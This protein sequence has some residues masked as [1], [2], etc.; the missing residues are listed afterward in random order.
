MPSPKIGLQTHVWKMQLFVTETQLKEPALVVVRHWMSY[1]L[2][3][4]RCWYTTSPV[5]LVSAGWQMA[6]ALVVQSADASISINCD[7]AIVTTFLFIT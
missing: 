4:L 5:P 3:V 6:G 1:P 2:E 7:S